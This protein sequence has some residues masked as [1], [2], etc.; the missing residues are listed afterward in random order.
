MIKYNCLKLE[1][2][3]AVIDAYR[4]VQT[5]KADKEREINKAQAYNNDILPRARGE[6]AKLLQEAEGYKREKQY[7]T[8]R[9]T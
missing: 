1:P 5:S 4:D 2:P 8:E 9:K 7:V 3:P 6:A